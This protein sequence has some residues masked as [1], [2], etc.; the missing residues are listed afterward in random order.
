MIAITG[1]KGGCGKTMTSLG[2][3]EA[4]ARAGEPSLAVDTDRQLPDLHTLARVNREPKLSSLDMVED[5][6]RIVQE[7]PRQKESYLVAAPDVSDHIDYNEIFAE[8]GR[9]LMQVLIDC[10]SGFGPNAVEPLAVTD[11][12]LIV[13]TSRTDSIK[14]AQR[15]EKMCQILDTP[16]A[17]ILVN[18]ANHV[19]VA[20]SGAFDA[21]ILGAIPEQ[22]QPLT[23]QQTRHAYDVVVAQLIERQDIDTDASPVVDTEAGTKRRLSTRVEKLDR[24]LGGG[25]VPGTV[26][27]LE[28]RGGM[29]ARQ[30]LTKMTASQHTYYVLS[31]LE[32][33]VR[34]R[35]EE[36]YGN[37]DTI[38]QLPEEGTLEAAMSHVQ[39]LPK[40]ANIVI[41]VIDSLERHDNRAYLDFLN[42]F[43]ASV[44]AADGIGVLHCEGG[45]DSPQNRQVTKQLAERVVELEPRNE[46]TCHLSL[47]GTGQAKTVGRQFEVRLSGP[48]VDNL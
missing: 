15:T 17:G 26:I 42:Q 7:N 39:D 47:S 20:V 38:K 13:T 3:A 14:V 41:D 16:V 34:E 9:L 31:G 44:Q 32:E 37:G 2:L 11:S 35:V 45:S 30:L 27:A 8:L 25:I 10:P 36:G 29:Q 4:F 48:S 43:L 19:P 24:A 33:S 12:A 6:E 40:Q 5:I 21:P 1:A 23:S 46:T 18:R 28:S 22:N